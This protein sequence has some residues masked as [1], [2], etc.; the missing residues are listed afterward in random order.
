MT[1]HSH[2]LGASRYLTLADGRRLHYMWKGSGEPTVVFESGMG[3]SRSAWGLVQPMAAPDARTVVYDRAGLGRSDPDASPRTL[4]RMAQDLSELLTALGPGPYILVG[5]SW[6]GPIVR[7]VAAMD[8]SRIRGLVL[9]D[10]SDEHCALYFSRLA[11]T[12]FAVM[13]GLLPP[14]AR[15]GLYRRMGSKEGRVL[16]A[17]VYK[18]HCAEDFTL[19]A[20]RAVANESRVFVHELTRLRVQPPELQGLEVTVISGTEIAKADRRIRP[21]LIAAHKRTVDSLDRARWVPAPNS[22]HMVLYSEPRLIVDEI[23]RLASPSP[24]L[25]AATGADERLARKDEGQIVEGCNV[26]GRNIED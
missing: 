14:M 21:A 4:A 19:A 7:T 3:A 9:V 1:S 17:D 25:V 16:P 13:R 26:E 23:A 18:D 5:H 24:P 20:A 22:G 11:R 12:N 2:S 6:G 15:F 8:K 10:P